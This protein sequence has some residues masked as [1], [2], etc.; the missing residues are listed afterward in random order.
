[1]KSSDIKSFLRHA[2]SQPEYAIFFEVANATG[3][4]G[5]RRWADAIAMSLWPSRGLLL[6]GIEIKVSRGDWLS[7]VKNPEKAEEIARYCDNWILVTAPNVA[8]DDEIPANW[9]WQVFDGKTLKTKKK[10]EMLDPQPLDRNFLAA[11]LRSAGKVDEAE[12][13]A[14]VQKQVD[15]ERARIDER[16][17]REVK[18]R[19]ERRDAMAQRYAALEAIF[20]DEDLRWIDDREFA[21]AIK[22]VLKLGIRGAYD[23]VLSVRDKAAEFSEK[24][25]KALA[26]MD[27]VVK[28][29]EHKRKV[30]V[31]GDKR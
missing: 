29:D 1:M 8:R 3:Y 23:G 20:S 25:D 31:V 10:P 21:E 16:I 11:L 17:E 24:M 18:W 9:G 4:S 22:L 7:E 26:A 2:Y 14:S 28:K 12:I 30:L 19:T 27:L 6:T 13:A 5:K 15:A